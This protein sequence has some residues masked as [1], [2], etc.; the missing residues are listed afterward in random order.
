MRKVVL[1]TLMSLDG[2]AENPSR[3]FAP[4]DRRA[5]PPEFDRAMEEDLVRIIGTQDAVL[6]GRRMYDEWSRYWPTADPEIPFTGFI[7]GVKKYVVTSRPLSRTWNNA[8]PVGGPVENVIRRLKG[9]PGGDI[10]VHGS[11]ELAQSLLAR[12]LVDELRLVVGPAFGFTGR[13]LWPAT[14]EIRRLELVSAT[15][16]PSGSVLL[17]YRAGSADRAPTLI[18]SRST[19]EAE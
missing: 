14:D 17:N 15:A 7:N 3:Y 12:G 9:E 6:L 4:E 10:G 19:R 13:K 5:G 8:E 2:D 18:P 16:T 11:V 1:Y